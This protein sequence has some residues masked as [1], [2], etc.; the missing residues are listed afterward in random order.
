MHLITYIIGLLIICVLPDT[1]LFWK[2]IKSGNKTLLYTQIITCSI[3]LLAIAGMLLG[4]LHTT[5]MIPVLCF[6]MVFFSLYLPKW[7]YLPFGL[8]NHHRTGIVISCVGFLTLLYGLCI[9]RTEVQVRPVIINSPH[10]PQSFNGYRIVQL[11]DMH[12]GSLIKDEYWLRHLPQ[13]INALAPDLVVFT[14]DLVNSY[15]SEA[16]GW[17]EIFAQIDA[18]DGKWACKGNH[19]YSHYNWR[20]DIDSIANIKAVES[21]YKRLEWKLLND[22][23]TI[24]QKGN[25]SIYLC[26]VQNISRAPFKSYG[27]LSKTLQSTNDSTA[28]IMLSHDPIAWEDSIKYH[29]N[30]VLTLSGH[31]HAMQLGLDCWGLHLSPASLMHPFWDGTYQHE[32]HGQYLHVNR[33][34]GY[35]GFPFRI[36]MKPEITL[37]ELHTAE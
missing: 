7:L 26:G 27:N 13:Q 14:G 23:S 1:L 30:V 9:G 6:G 4:V 8:S 15:A 12:L 18:K 3:F 22:S 36:G 16:D 19:D 25:D 34:I 31:T 29:K 35:V 24:I 5:S 20:G 17:E 11:S 33:G 37:I 32:Y 21:A 10:I 2:A 28:I